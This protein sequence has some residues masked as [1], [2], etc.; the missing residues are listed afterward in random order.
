M[1]IRTAYRDYSISLHFL[2]NI[3][4]VAIVLMPYMVSML[5][6]GH[7]MQT[8]YNRTYIN[9]FILYLEECLSVYKKVT[10][11]TCLVLSR[12]MRLSLILGESA[13]IY[14]FEKNSTLLPYQNSLTLFESFREL[15]RSLSCIVIHK[16][17]VEHLVY[18][19]HHR[20][21]KYHAHF[22]DYYMSST[23]KGYT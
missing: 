8:H 16:N 20:K 10:I 2:H 17:T 13:G 14:I 5:C 22:Q 1:Y 3:I 6:V 23:M 4:S 9:T 12:S 7:F 21:V 11:K 15:I 18:H 19:S